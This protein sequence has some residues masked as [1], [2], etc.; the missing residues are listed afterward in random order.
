MSEQKRDVSLWL[1][2]FVLLSLYF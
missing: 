1:A 2:V